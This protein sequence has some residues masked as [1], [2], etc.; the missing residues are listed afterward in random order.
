MSRA[1][2]AAIGQLSAGVDLDS[3]IESFTEFCERRN[4]DGSISER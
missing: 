2:I 4:L 3:L 1:V